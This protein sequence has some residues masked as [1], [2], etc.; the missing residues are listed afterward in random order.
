VGEHIL[1]PVEYHGQTL[2]MVLD[3][4][5]P[6]SLLWPSATE[7]LHLRTARLDDRPDGFKVKIDGQSVT[8]TA[9]VDSL[10]IGSYRIAR[11]DFFVD[12]RARP[13]ESPSDHRVLGSLGISEL[14]PV[15]FELDLAHRRFNLYSADHCP[16]APADWPDRYSRIPM[17]LNELGSV[18]FPLELDGS[19]IEAAFS[20]TS[21]ETSM[22]TDVSRQVFGFDE[23]SPRAQVQ[24][25]GSGK[26]YASFRAKTLAAGDLKLSDVAIRLA[27]AKKYCTLSN[28]GTFGDVAEFK[29]RDDH[30][31][32]GVYPLVLG[33]RVIEHLR[34]YFAIR[35]KVIY[36]TA[37]E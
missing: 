26:S 13:N 7:S 29:G 25:D 16:K 9:A 2:W 18:Y 15:D 22:S 34:L 10:K 30:L 21:L 11:R 3:L 19:K 1:V 33:R 5:E 27:P 14:W 23:H 8:I 35:E 36:V 24:I 37:L 32:Y 12:P 6:L 4:G 28:T 17:E 31:C 20:T